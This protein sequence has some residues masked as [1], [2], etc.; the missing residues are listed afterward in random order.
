MVAL[1][2]NPAGL[3]QIE[4]EVALPGRG[5]AFAW[6]IILCCS[7]IQH[8]GDARTQ[9]LG[10]RCLARPERSQDLQDMALG[11]IGHRHV[12]DDGIGEPCQ[13][14]FP[15]TAVDGARPTD[16][17]RGDI[18][19]GAGFEGLGSSLARLPFA[20]TLFALSLLLF[21]RID[22]LLDLLLQNAGLY[23]GVIEAQPIE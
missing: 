18:G 17:L 2:S 7:V 3:G 16:F 21:E 12:A 22:L 6:P 11:H 14:V 5:V 8:R 9:S 19:L 23:A 13:R 15:L 10:R 1:W 4:S 20:L